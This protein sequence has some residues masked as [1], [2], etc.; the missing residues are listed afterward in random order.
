MCML[1]ELIKNLT[2]DKS[3][4]SLE[5]KEVRAILQAQLLGK[6]SSQPLLI[7]SDPFYT[8]ITDQR[9]RQ[10]YYE[11]DLKNTPYDIDKH[12]CDDFSVRFK[13]ELAKAVTYDWS[14]KYSYAAGIV[15]GSIPTPHAIN[16]FI[17]PEKKLMFFEPQ[18]GEVFEPKGKNIFFLFS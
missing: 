9:I 10:I 6:L 14:S 18:T 15:F 11:A 8:T 3:L 7:L 2:F 1:I 12:D 17:T 4:P 5:N 13:G 16:W